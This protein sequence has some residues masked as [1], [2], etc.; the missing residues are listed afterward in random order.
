ME[1]EE[2]LKSF[3]FKLPENRPRISR[4]TRKHTNL[5]ERFKHFR[6]FRTNQEKPDKEFV[7][8]EKFE[9]FTRMFH[10]WLTTLIWQ[11][12]FSHHS[13]RIQNRRSRTIG[14][15]ETTRMQRCRRQLMFNSMITRFRNSN[16]FTHRIEWKRGRPG[17]QYLRP[18]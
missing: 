14:K 18:S 2:S 13:F 6:E 9:Y 12:L 3:A 17:L 4:T 7:L 10:F 11:Q 8:V 16:E 15:M 5:L 1:R